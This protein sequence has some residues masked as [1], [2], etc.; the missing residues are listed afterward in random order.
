M[1]GNGTSRNVVVRTGYVLWMVPGIGIDNANW[2]SVRNKT[3]LFVRL[4]T[5]IRTRV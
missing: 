5:T 1:F 2:Y 4:H 3:I